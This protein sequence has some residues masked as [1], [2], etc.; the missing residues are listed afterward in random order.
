MAGPVLLKSGADLFVAE[1][2]AANE[3]LAEA[4]WGALFSAN[5]CAL[6]STSDCFRNGLLPL[7]MPGESD[8]FC[9]LHAFTLRSV[10]AARGVLVVPDLRVVSEA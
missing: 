2:G 1:L 8:E 3:L 5:H 6:G 4:G 9:L 7:R 10:L